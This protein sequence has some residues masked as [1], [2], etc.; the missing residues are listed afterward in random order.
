MFL[1]ARATPNERGHIS[2]FARFYISGAP[3]SS[4]GVASESSPPGNFGAVRGQAQRAGA[5]AFADGRGG[6][7]PVYALKLKRGRRCA[8]PPHSRAAILSLLRGSCPSTPTPTAGAVG[9]F[10][11]LLRS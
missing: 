6:L 8:L 3:A 10:L 2:T 9:Y 1:V 4:H 11:A 7:A 5:L